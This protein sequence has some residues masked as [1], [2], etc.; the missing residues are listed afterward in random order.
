[1]N[2]RGRIALSVAVLAMAPFLGGPAAP[3]PSGSAAAPPAPDPLSAALF[4]GSSSAPPEEA[5]TSATPIAGVRMGADARRN[6]CWVRHIA[7]WVRVGCDD[8][9]AA[10]V[11]LL[12]GEKRDLSILG[13]KEGYQ[14]ESMT[15]QFSMRPGDRRILQWI[16]ADLWETVWQG[17][18]GEWASDAPTPNGPMFGMA[19]QVDWA[20]GSEPTLSMF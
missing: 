15:A 10:R 16:V 2:S 3:P 19:V 6:A 4:A 20:S 18:N 7:E 11:D 12:A 13:S 17:E 1:M 5:W 9:R 14:G 8:L